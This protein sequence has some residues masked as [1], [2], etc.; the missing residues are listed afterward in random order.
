MISD[1]RCRSRK[2]RKQRKQRT[3]RKLGVLNQRGGAVANFQVYAFTTKPLSAANN[4]SLLQALKSLYGDDVS[5]IKDS[6]TFPND[7]LKEE[8]QA[9]VHSKEG[10]YPTLTTLTGFSIPVPSSFKEGEMT[11][12]KITVEEYSIR[13]KLRSLKVPFRLVR[14]QHGLWSPEFAIIALR[15]TKPN[16]HPK[17]KTSSSL[18]HSSNHSL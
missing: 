17:P 12:E 14:A 16:Q 6:D 3:T 11:D 1:K 10:K 7:Y 15:K 9:F 4:E 2:Y 5:E 18:S 13:D 8:I